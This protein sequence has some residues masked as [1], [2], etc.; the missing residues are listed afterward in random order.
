MIHL[1]CARRAS[2]ISL[3]AILILSA[4]PAAAHRRA[5]IPL[6]TP[7]PSLAADVNADDASVVA[8]PDPSFA[9]V[10]D[11]APTAAYLANDDDTPTIVKTARRIFCVEYAR[12]RSG[13]AIF[14]DAKTWWDKA[15]GLYA[16]STAP[17]AG[18]V[19]VFAGS[20]KMR[21]GHVAVVTR[22][23]SS[24]EIVVDHANWARD[25]NIYL[26]MPVMD[27]SEQNDWSAVRV[28]NPQ[29]NQWGSRTYKIDGFIAA[30][31][32]A[33]ARSGA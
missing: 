30:K 32:A 31:L 7:R 16:E 29:G 15:R 8:M 6:P 10:S 20:K 12:L 4:G 18:A 27:V 11:V 9:I 17:D 5:Y 33:A 1:D 3:A 23:V 22:I 25:G 13:I 21:K 24:R 14:G 2:A 26:N 28:W 19:M